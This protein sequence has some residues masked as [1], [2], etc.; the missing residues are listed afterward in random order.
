MTRPSSDP[1]V[2]LELGDGRVDGS[3]DKA[4]CGGEGTAKSPVDS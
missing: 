4:P 2:G 1:I 3:V